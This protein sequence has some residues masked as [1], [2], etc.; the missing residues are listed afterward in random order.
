MHVAGVLLRARPEA[1]AAVHGALVRMPG[2]EVHATTGDGR[3]VV[4]V[5]SAGAGAAAD[6][7]SA[8]HDVDGVVGVALVYEQSA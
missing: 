6:V 7:F 8:L 5:E 1:V 4:T 3:M 2:V